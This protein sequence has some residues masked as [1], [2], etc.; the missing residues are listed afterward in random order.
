MPDD[1]K[2]TKAERTGLQE[3][4]DH[5]WCARTA[6]VLDRLVKRKLIRRYY[7]PPHEY[8]LT[9]SGAVALGVDPDSRANVPLGYGD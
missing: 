4:H 5:W 8:V 9:R 1:S 2:L 3:V 6:P 7:K